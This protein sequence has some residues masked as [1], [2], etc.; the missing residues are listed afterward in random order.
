VFYLTG[1]I[2]GS[3]GVLVIFKN[4]NPLFFSTKLDIGNVANKKLKTIVFE[5][6]VV[7]TLKKHISIKKIIGLDF[8]SLSLGY[9]QVI[10]KALKPKKLID[11]SAQLIEQR[12]TKDAYELKQITRAAREICSLVGNAIK[13][14]AKFSYEHEV[15][16]YIETEAR[17]KGLPMSF[18]TIVASGK[19]ASNPHYIACSDRLRRG[20]LVIDCGVKVNGYCSDITRTIFL[21][22]PTKEEVALY[23]KVL[24]VQERCIQMM[25]EHKSVRAADEFAQKELGKAFVHALGHGIGL[26]V[27]ESPRVSTYN[28]DVIQNNACFTIEPGIYY[29]GKRG[30]RIEDDLVKVNN[31]VKVITPLTKKLI[32]INNKIYK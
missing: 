4:R 1:F 16:N 32:T 10:K 27:H 19:N 31:K 7:D 13:N 8:A 22:T 3:I 11:V 29:L 30:I 12:A 25:K 6:S 9:Y 14:I 5:K 17:K 15:K 20:F 26:D 18:N 21:G 2:G 24:N 28:K 23:M